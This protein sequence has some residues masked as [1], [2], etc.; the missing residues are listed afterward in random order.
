MSDHDHNHD[1]PHKHP[2]QTDHP[3]PSSHYELVGVA[4]NELLIEKGVYTAAEMRSVIESIDTVDPAHGAQVVAR[5]WVDAAYRAELLADGCAAVQ[6]LGLNPSPAELT[7]L[8]NTS[9][10]HNVV[11]CTLCSCYPRTLLGICS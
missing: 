5:A 7:V 11:V 6:K 3:E 8:E 9:R 1:H 4:L 2:H 10:V